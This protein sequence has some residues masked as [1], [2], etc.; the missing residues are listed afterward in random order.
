MTDNNKNTCCYSRGKFCKQPRARK[1]NAHGYHRF[2]KYHQDESIKSQRIRD[3]V[4]RRKYGSTTTERQEKR[5]KRRYCEPNSLIDFRTPPPYF[6]INEF[7]F[8]C[9][10]LFDNTMYI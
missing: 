10:C 3:S 7:A 5:G 4:R 6:T 2:C 1:V 9:D 8:L